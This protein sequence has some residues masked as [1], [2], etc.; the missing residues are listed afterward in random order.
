MAS[1]SAIDNITTS[2]GISSADIRS[3][4]DFAQTQIDTASDCLTAY[5]S[6]NASLDSV[7][8]SDYLGTASGDIS[9]TEWSNRKI[10]VKV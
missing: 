7:Y 2:F 10:C 8:L 9:T 1:T 4:L 6:F 5:S 3:N